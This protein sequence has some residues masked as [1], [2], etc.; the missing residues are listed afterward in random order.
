MESGF[1]LSTEALINT[2][3]KR[4]YCHYNEG[5]FVLGYGK[6]NYQL[7]VLETYTD[8]PDSRPILTQVTS[9][10]QDEENWNT[11][12]RNPVRPNKRNIK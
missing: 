4:I 6:D 1:K 9:L 2:K 5:I 3:N 8:F 7:E 11:M 12:G 10:I